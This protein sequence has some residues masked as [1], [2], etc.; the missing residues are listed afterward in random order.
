MSQRR[1][2]PGFP[3]LLAMGVLA[4]NLFV[5]AVVALSLRSSRHQDRLQAETTA[6]N[7]CQ[8]L[9]QNLVGTINQINLALLA[10]KDEAEHQI[11]TGG[12]RGKVLNVYIAKQSAYLPDIHGVRMANKSGEEVYGRGVAADPRISLAGRDYFRRS[13]DDP[14][15]Q[16]LVSD[17]VVDSDAGT[18]VIIFARRINRPDG[19]FA[20]MVYARVSLEHLTWALSLVDVG[21]HGVVSLRGRDMAVLARYPITGDHDGQLGRTVL[22][23]QFKE[24]LNSDRSEG[25]YTAHSAL[26]G[27]ERTFTFRRISGHPFFIVLGLASSDYLAAWRHEATR[28]WALAALFCLFTLLAW[29]TTYYAWKRRLAAQTEIARLAHIVET[30]DDAVMSISLEGKVLSWNQAAER[31]YGYTWEELVTNVRVLVPEER[32]EEFERIRQ[33][34]MAGRSLD[35]YESIRVKKSGERVPVSLTISPLRD[36][37]GRITGWSAIARDLT[38]TKKA[39]RLEEQFR[40]AQKL[41]SLGRLTGGVAHDFNNLLMVISS[42]TEMVQEQLAPENPLRRKTEQVLH[43]AAR[44]ASLTQQML[45]FSRKQVLSPKIIDLNGVLADTTGMLKRMIGEDIDLLFFPDRSLWPIQA[46]PGQITQVLLNLC[47]N[48]RDAMPTGGKLTIETQNVTIAEQDASRQAGC[49]AGDYAM[50]AVTD[51]GTGMSQEVQERIFEPFFTTKEI[52]KG[53][54]LGLSMVYGIVKQSGGYVSVYSEPGK[55]SC[56]KLYFSRAHEVVTETVVSRTPVRHGKGQTILVVE[57]EEPLRESIVDY[58]SAHG[59]QILP[60][61]SGR[62]ALDVAA[63]HNGSIDLLLTDVVMPG[64]SGPELEAQLRNSDGTIRTLYMSGYTDQAIVN[65]GM[66]Y[67]QAAFLQK[68]FS[69]HAL[70]DKLKDLL[71]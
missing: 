11:A 31:L 57:D 46:D 58:L 68:P 48:A 62:Q 30:T 41:E 50:L 12:I 56:F 47:V 35:H 36:Q 71:A 26:D 32:Q 16:L 64:M 7:L 60:A 15:A 34:V 1:F 51:N 33:A 24:L 40:Q 22:S 19:S 42:Y 28:M 5:I 44:G 14:Q 29:G 38:E 49:A 25:T 39:E 2:V 65:H 20:G 9:E 6:R 52:G 70:A 63:R 37:T 67:S 21:S 3:V 23:P 8:V 69:L 17:L 10:V 61:S 53:T 4:V 66:L 43:A 55:G 13:R 18:H 45:A 54:G 27:V 59:Y